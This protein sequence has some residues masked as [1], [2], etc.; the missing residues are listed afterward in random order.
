MKKTTLL[1]LLISAFSLAQTS[2]LEQKINSIIKNKKATVGVSVLGFEN[3][4]KY[5][6]NGD[7]KLPMQSVFKFHIAAAVLNAVDQGKLSLDQKIML[8][9][10]NLLENTWSPLRD[11]YPAGNIEIPLSE[12]IEYTVAKSDN[13]GCDILLRLLGGTQVVQKFM[14]SKGV[15]GFQ[16]KYN[17]EDMHKDW[18]V[19]YENYSTTKSAADVLKKLYDGKLLSKKSTDYLMKVML[20]TSTGLNK[21]VEQLP[22]N[23]PVAR[24]TGA[25]GKNNAGLTGAE[26][27]IGIVTLPNG[28][29]YALAVFVSNSM[30]TDAVNCRMISDISKE[31]WEYFNK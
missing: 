7:K 12:V 14:D 10:S 9:Q 26:N 31:V 21:M 23:T 5:D 1:F 3:G 27:E 22:K 2:L 29:H 18:N 15:K 8:N 11:K 6:K 28:K 30:E 17:E 19:Q 20:S 25:S 24:K 4:F 13:N 16:I